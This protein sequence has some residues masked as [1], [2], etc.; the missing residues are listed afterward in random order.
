MISDEDG[1]PRRCGGQGDA[2]SG[3]L[4]LFLLWANRFSLIFPNIVCVL[5]IFNL[6]T[7]RNNKGSLKQLFRIIDISLKYCIHV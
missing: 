1:S 7:F 5:S 2:C 6:N 4:A 3:S